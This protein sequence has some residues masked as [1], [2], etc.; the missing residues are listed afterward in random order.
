[1]L[2][3]IIQLLTHKKRRLFLLAS[4]ALA[5]LIFIGPVHSLTSGS[6]ITINPT[7]RKYW[8]TN[9]WRM[10]TPQDQGMDAGTLAMLDQTIRAKWP[11]IH[12]ILVVRHGYLVFEKYYANFGPDNAVEVTSVTKSFISALIGI[13]LQNKFLD[14]V[15]QK[16]VD[17]FPEYVT[18]YTDPRTKEITL[19]NLLTMTSGLDWSE[20]SAWQWPQS[21]D[22]IKFVIDTSMSSQPG[23]K[24][25]YNTPAVHILSG[26]LTKVTQTNT[27]AFAD[28]YLFQPLGISKPQWLTDPQGRNNG[29]RELFLT[30]RDMA[31]YGYLYLNNGFWD[32]RQIVPSEWVKQSTQAQSS[33]G[34]PQN[35]SYGYLWWVTTVKGHPA[36]FA[37]GYGGQ[38]IYVVPALDVVVVITS[39]FEHEHAENK[40]LVPQFIV[41]AILN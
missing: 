9:G 11:H 6:A 23:S 8:P 12:S 36:Y 30:P 5:L 7:Q 26:I 18:P 22:W 21:G 15:D 33:G 20:Q 32:G 2:H 38:F 1:M 31:K 13:A 41:S 10:S 16:V 35:V 17:F 28:T 3:E 14:S 4:C 25:T 29:G 27:L 40:D 39:D 19:R 34:F 24:F 37:A